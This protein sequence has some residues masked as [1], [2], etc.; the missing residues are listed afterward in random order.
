MDNLEKVKSPINKENILLLIIG[1]LLVILA[2]SFAYIKIQKSF[3]WEKDGTERIIET[4]IQ[5]TSSQSVMEREGFKEVFA[6]ASAITADNKVLSDNFQVADNT[7]IP[8][9]P[10]A[11]KSVVVNKE[12]LPKEILN[13]K[14][15]DNK[16]TPSSFM[17]K[18]GNLISLAVTSADGKVHGFSFYNEK[19]G[20]ISMGVDSYET[21][22]INFNAPEP[23][24]YEFACGI[25]QHRANG[26]KGVMI[27]K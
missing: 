22:A 12:E 16:I 6:G 21:K 10:Q 15:G 7:A 1:V 13:L 4:G 24:E 3:N 27:V 23:G 5:A 26:E 8:G 9:S 14:I 18:A 17:V 20:A 19:M 25:P 11:P 2:V